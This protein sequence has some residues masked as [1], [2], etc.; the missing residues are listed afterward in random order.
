MKNKGFSAITVFLGMVT[1]LII[2]AVAIAVFNKSSS[3]PTSKPNGS[4]IVP[5]SNSLSFKTLSP[6]TVPSKTAECVEPINYSSSG[7]PMPYEC[8]NNEL[9]ITEWKALAA[10]EPSLLRLGY[11]PSS[12]QVQAALCSDV[13]ANISNSIEETVYSIASLYYGW[14]F[15]S[16]PELIILNGTCQN[17]DD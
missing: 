1:C 7:V 5:Q 17:I 3:P 14:H 10:L 13:K 2:L 6:A 4:K 12:T 15:T 16:N 11:N 8:S 9:N